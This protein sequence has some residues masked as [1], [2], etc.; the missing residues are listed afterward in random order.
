MDGER[1]SAKLLQSVV[2]RVIVSPSQEKPK[3]CFD[4]RGVKVEIIGALDALSSNTATGGFTSTPVGE[5]GG[6]AGGT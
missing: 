1:P 6:S 5:V 4:R 3:S 2:D